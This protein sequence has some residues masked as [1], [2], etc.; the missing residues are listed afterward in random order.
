MDDVL[1]GVVAAERFHRPHL[2]ADDL[3]VPCRCRCR[4]RCRCHVEVEVLPAA[5]CA[6]RHAPFAVH[7]R[8]AKGAVNGHGF[9]QGRFNIH[10]L[11][12]S[13]NACLVSATSAKD[14]LLCR[15]Y[16]KKIDY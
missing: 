7:E 8:R 11:P 9:L 5:G 16:A 14:W 12:P 6:K 1:D 4:C 13:A 2:R 3:R 15:E 10:V